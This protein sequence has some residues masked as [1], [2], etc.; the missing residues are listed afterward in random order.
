MSA[1]E[2]LRKYFP[3]DIWAPKET[4]IFIVSLTLAPLEG[5]KGPTKTTVFPPDR[6]RL[7]AELRVGQIRRDMCQMAYPDVA[8]ADIIA[9]TDSLIEGLRT[10]Q[11]V[12]IEIHEMALPPPFI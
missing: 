6:T 11:Q 5:A 9:Q 10:Q 3:G 7:N 2:E 12:L 4:P 8:P 1:H